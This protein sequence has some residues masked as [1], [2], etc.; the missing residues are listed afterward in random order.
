MTGLRL[1]R[2]P[3]IPRGLGCGLCQLRGRGGMQ[4]LLEV[5]EATLT[6]CDEEGSCFYDC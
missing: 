3:V 4:F 5:F 1:T 2:L 6:F